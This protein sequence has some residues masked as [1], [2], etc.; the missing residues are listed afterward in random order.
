MRPSFRVSVFCGAHIGMYVCDDGLDED[1]NKGG[2]SHRHTTHIIHGTDGGPTDARR[3]G[4]RNGASAG[5]TTEEAQA[6]RHRY[7]PSTPCTPPRRGSSGRCR[8]E[9][10]IPSSWFRE[11]YAFAFS[12]VV[13]GKSNIFPFGDLAPLII[14]SQTVKTRGRRRWTEASVSCGPSWLLGW[15]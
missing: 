14:T 4:R 8:R 9:G 12:V 11:V 1:A 10:Q 5:P 6:P 3:T 13:E 15:G 2:E 7:A